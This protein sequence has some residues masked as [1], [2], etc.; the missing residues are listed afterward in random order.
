VDPIEQ[1]NL[2]LQDANEVD[3][4]KTSDGFP[5]NGNSDF[6][7][8]EEESIPIKSHK[9]FSIIDSPTNAHEMSDRSRCS[10]QGRQ[11]TQPRLVN[12]NHFS[13]KSMGL[14][15]VMDTSPIRSKAN[16][17][18]G[19][20]EKSIVTI[21]SNNRS[22]REVRNIVNSFEDLNANLDANGQCFKQS[23]GQDD[24]DKSARTFQTISNPG[25]PPKSGRSV[26]SRR[27]QLTV[28]QNTTPRSKSRRSTDRITPGGR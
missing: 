26:N 1:A 19:I 24:K 28:H 21:S 13:E 4:H 22:G 8:E 25:L 6:Y 14:S 23:I 15:K 27:S 11:E 9:D 5:A 7:S 2:D 10:K 17:Y 18:Q 12:S 16:S 20:K 3:Y